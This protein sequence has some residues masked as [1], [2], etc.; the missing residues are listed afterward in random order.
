MGSKIV[1]VW[2]NYVET[3]D[4]KLMANDWSSQ[5]IKFGYS[6]SGGYIFIYNL[7]SV[8]LTADRKFRIQFD[9]LIDN[10]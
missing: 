2:G 7:T 4:V 1:P 3:K 6:Y 8:T 5:D 10:Q 9:L